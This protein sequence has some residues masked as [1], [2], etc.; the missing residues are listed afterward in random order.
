[1]KTLTCPN[2]GGSWGTYLFE[3]GV[4]YVECGEPLGDNRRAPGCGWKGTREDLT[5]VKEKK[6][7][8][9]IPKRSKKMEAKYVERR[10]L[11]ARLL[12]ERPVCQ[13]CLAARSTE[14]HEVLTRARGGSILE[15]DNCLAL[16]HE[17]HSWVTDHPKLATEAGLMASR[18]HPSQN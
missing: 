8:K 14:I 11:V 5:V 16:C 1:M 18:L 13:K 15:E 4:A 2:C 6:V 3:Y 7:R 17:C 12:E 10:K 9:P